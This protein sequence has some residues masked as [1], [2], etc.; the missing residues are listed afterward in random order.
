MAVALATA[1]LGAGAPTA[2]AATFTAA[3][4]PR[5]VGTVA[6]GRT[7]TISPGTWSPT[8]TFV[9]RFFRTCSGTTTK[10]SVGSTRTYTLTPA[11][12]GCTIRGQVEGRK[13]GYTTTVRTSPY[14]VPVAPGTLTGTAPRIS[15]TVAVG[16]RLTAST[17]GWPVGTT[18][19]YRW[20]KVGPD[21]RQYPL[22]TGYARTV[23][24]SEY[25]Y[26]YLVKVSGAKPGYT[27]LTLS[28][29]AT[30]YNFNSLQKTMAAR[31]KAFNDL[32]YSGTGPKVITLP[33]TV[34][35]A[36][37]MATHDGESRF[38]VETTRSDGQLDEQL[39][40]HIGPY[41]GTT[42]YGINGYDP[43]P[44]RLEV[45]ADGAWTVR[46]RAIALAPMLYTAAA[47]SSDGVRLFGGGA[48]TWAATYA[49]DDYFIVQTEN[50]ALHEHW[51]E[52]F[53]VQ[54]PYAGSGAHAAGPSVV[55]VTADAAW[56][57][58]VS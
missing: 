38:F 27:T 1:L 55:T 56:T 58:K 16:S 54:G 24:S 20:Y 11:D 4:V 9:Y 7:L 39:V 51:E 18:L 8:P 48:G 44:T 32:V 13:T 34:D 50:P 5:L 49:G 28:S 45:V 35:A 12:L 2:S 6:V 41:S 26:R 29:A 57:L 25:G 3:P 33:S 14:S 17:S 53:R 42:V 23:T 52:V 31:Y 21:R 43:D 10:L 15:G 36:L 30:T 40:S 19:T 47:G 22:S 37:V 46:I